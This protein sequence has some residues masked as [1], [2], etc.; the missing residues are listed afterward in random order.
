MMSRVSQNSWIQPLL[1]ACLALFVVCQ[2]R[3]EA[4]RAAR[5]VK[6]THV[7]AK[8]G[9]DRN[10]VFV[11]YAVEY[12][13]LPKPPGYRVSRAIVGDIA[14]TCSPGLLTLSLGDRQGRKIPDA[15]GSRRL[16]KGGRVRVPFR[17]P[18]LA[19]DV[20]RVYVAIRTSSAQQIR[21]FTP[22]NTPWT[23]RRRRF[24]RGL[25]GDDRPG[26]IVGSA[27]RD[28]IIG[29][30][31]SDR[32]LGLTRGDC[33]LGGRGADTLLGGRGPD[34]LAGGPGND[35]VFGVAGRDILFG[36]RGVDLLKGGPSRDILYA[37]RRRDLLRGGPG[38]DWLWGGPGRDRMFGGG[39]N[40]TLY[41]GPGND[42]LVGGRGLDRCVGGLGRDR[43]I[44]CE[45]VVG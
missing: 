25:V 27:Q 9:C 36:G 1:L 3:P 8:S 37:G 19:E 12:R 44:G 32:L 24:D 33:V 10:G 4:P 45:R 35:R 39:G 22:L 16:T 6:G 40:D 26:T 42:V 21:I 28:L 31:G 23:C 38:R 29:L 2:I 43:F 17:V 15:A 20:R 5:L 7:K 11:H 13:S 30:G 18:P 41:G 34:V 14:E